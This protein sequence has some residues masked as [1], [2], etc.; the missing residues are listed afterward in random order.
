MPN[1]FVDTSILLYAASGRRADQDKAL[2]ARQLLEKEDVGL[3]T[4]VLQE[5]YAHAV[6]PR[7]LGLTPAE[8]AQYCETWLQFPV[9]PLTMDT[10]LHA[11]ELMENHALSNW[12]ATILA[13]A[14]QLHCTILYSEDLPHGHEFEG[15]RVINPFSAV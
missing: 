2:V 5:F 13:T 10:F 11:L 12:D 15:I 9:A 14:A 1:A 3:S 6:Q 4:Q 8:A 7:K